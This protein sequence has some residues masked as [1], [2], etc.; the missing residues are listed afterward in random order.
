M[1]IF[2]CNIKQEGWHPNLP[3]QNLKQQMFFDMTKIKSSPAS[4]RGGVINE[5][6]VC[7]C[8]SKSYR[9]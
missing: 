2:V 8:L 4:K 1:S 7:C 3:T 6:C 9:F 5:F